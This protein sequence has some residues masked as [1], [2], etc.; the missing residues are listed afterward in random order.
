MT[1]PGSAGPPTGA[2]CEEA[3]GGAAPTDRALLALCFSFLALG[4]ALGSSLERATALSATS[5]SATTLSATTPTSVAAP[6]H[7]DDRDDVTERAGRAPR[8]MTVDPAGWMAVTDETSPVDP[9]AGVAAAPG[10]TQGHVDPARSAEGSGSFGQP[11]GPVDGA[12]A[13]RAQSTSGRA[14]IER[15]IRAAALEF[16]VDGEAL[17]RVA[18]CE[19][20]LDLL[21]IGPVGELGV[22]QFQPRT[23]R[24]NAR[25]LGY[26][27]ADILD[28]RAQARVAAEMFSRGQSWQWSCAR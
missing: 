6:A 4:L 12:A 1:P 9:A 16:G 27:L 11:Q 23:F 8:R 18:L 24:A 10:H 13:V 20:Q 15:I 17:V 2:R 14:E 5:L 25:R 19:S 7:A 3:A 21:A 28:V 26:T 22:L